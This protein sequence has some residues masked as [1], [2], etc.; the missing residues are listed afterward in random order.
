MFHNKRHKPKDLGKN[1]WSNNWMSL[2]AK[3]RRATSK[4][5]H[6]KKEECGHTHL[7]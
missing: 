5:K 6:G 3:S 2:G 7:N 4:L 1:K